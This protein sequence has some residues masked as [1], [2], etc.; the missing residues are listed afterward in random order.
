MSLFK[1]SIRVED[2]AVFGAVVDRSGD[3][4]V[5]LDGPFT[6]GTIVL[7]ISQD[8]FWALQCAVRDAIVRDLNKKGVI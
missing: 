4:M 7:K 6:E 2:N 3:L 1:T 5:S 8:S